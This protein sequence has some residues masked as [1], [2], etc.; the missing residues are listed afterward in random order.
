MHR[1]RSSKDI[2]DDIWGSCSINS[3]ATTKLLAVF[4]TQPNR[5]A[6]DYDSSNRIGFRH[7]SRDT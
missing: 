5:K 4:S 6:N 7:R 3:S 1:A 2:H